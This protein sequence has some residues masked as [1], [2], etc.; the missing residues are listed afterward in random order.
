MKI[1]RETSAAERAKELCVGRRRF[2]SVPRRERTELSLSKATSPGGTKFWTRRSSETCCQTISFIASR[3]GSC[4]PKE[5]GIGAAKKS[6]VRFRVS[7]T[8]A[9]YFIDRALRIKDGQSQVG[10]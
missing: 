10:S 7:S 2:S 3:L 8:Y 9:S 1:R 5:G 4:D 6:R